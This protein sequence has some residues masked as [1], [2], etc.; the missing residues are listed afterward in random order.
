MIVHVRPV[1]ISAATMSCALHVGVV[2]LLGCGVYI[3]SVEGWQQGGQ[4]KGHDTKSGV[5]TDNI[6]LLYVLV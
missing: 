5:A 6:F 2:Q 4:R 1:L 3:G